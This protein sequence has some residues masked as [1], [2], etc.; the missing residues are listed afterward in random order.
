MGNPF[1]AEDLTQDVFLCAYKN[2]ASFDGTYEKAWLSKIAVHK[3]LDFLKA[4]GRRT[5]PTED[6]YFSVLTDHSSSP[7]EA[8]LLSDSKKQV[9]LLCQKLKSPYREVAAAHF[10]DEMSVQ[11]ISAKRNQNPRTIQT[12]L[13][14]AKKMLKALLN[15]QNS[16]KE[17]RG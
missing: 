17:R 1:D 8:C 14:R 9:Y 13:Y 7:E 6:S 4:S 11:E 3:C 10:C 15:P 5:I 12:Q 2:L 16:P